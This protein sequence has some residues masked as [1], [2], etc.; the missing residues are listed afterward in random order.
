[1]ISFQYT[2]YWSVQLFP[3]S[4]L[5]LRWMDQRVRDGSRTLAWKSSWVSALVVATLCMSYQYGALLQ[6][7]ITMGGLAGTIS[8]LTRR[9]TSAAPEW[10]C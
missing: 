8:G 6:H 3:A 9:T 5:N 7:D 4:L 1:M 2:A 10:P